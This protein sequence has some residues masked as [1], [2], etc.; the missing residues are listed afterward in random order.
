MGPEVVKTVMAASVVVIS[1]ETGCGK[2]TQVH[3]L[4]PTPPNL[5]PVPYTTPF[6]LHPTP[7]N[8]PPILK[9]VPQF[10]L[11]H[12]IAAGHG[13]DVNIVC[14]QPRRISAI[15]VHL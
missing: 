12:L 3:T 4:N 10:I 2:T 7:Y 8:Q 5:N 14:T 9:Q 13:G 15:G 1:G 6:N 11:D